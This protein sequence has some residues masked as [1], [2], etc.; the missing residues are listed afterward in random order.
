MMQ[1]RARE[2]ASLN[3]PCATV[4]NHTGV[5]HFWFEQTGPGGERL[6]VLVVRATFDFA[7]C[8]A[9]MTLAQTQQEIVLGDVYA[10]TAGNA[11]MRAVVTDDGDVLPYKPG[12]D[13]LVTGSASA[14]DGIAATEWIAGIRVG[15]VKKLL[16]LHGPRQFRKQMMGWSLGPAQA[17][18]HVALDY[19]L[20]YGGCIDIPAEL[21]EGAEAD[22]VAHPGNPAGCGWLPGADAYAHL[23]RQA[24]AHVR[25]WIAAQ[26]EL[27]APQIEDAVEAVGNPYAYAAPQ[28]FSATARWWAPRVEMQGKYDDMWRST[29][30]P[31]L[32]K[33]FD[34]RYFQCASPGLVATPHLTGDETVTL[35]G[36]LPARCEMTL[37]G[38]KIIVA[39]TRASGVEEISLPLLDTLRF[40]LAT[41][42]ASLVWRTH[43]DSD[44]PVLDIVIAATTAQ[45]VSNGVVIG[46]A[47][48]AKEGG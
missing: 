45:I 11:V 1:P 44:D 34:S 46:N 37:P 35:L 13:V 22:W 23:P 16:R 47:V 40:D 29:R 36:L 31:L 18:T 14:P 6:D 2:L 7:S 43:F 15:T 24:R 48:A 41:R 38:W 27:T 26:K 21:T 39:V 17:V 25:K 19:R 30:Y 42:Q 33:E 12:T 5:P 4:V 3:S 10:G 9:V 20:A 28:G 32:P 8:G